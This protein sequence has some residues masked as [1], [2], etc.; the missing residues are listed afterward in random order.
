MHRYLSR[1]R[2]ISLAVTFPALIF[3]CVA[4]VSSYE[5]LAPPPP[6]IAPSRYAKKENP[7]EFNDASVAAGKK[8]YIAQCIACHGK[9]GHGDGARASELKPRPR[10][11]A[12]PEMWLETDGEIYYKIGKGRTP[13]PSFKKIISS[14]QNWQVINYMRTLS[15]K[16]SV[17]GYR[18][19]IGK[20]ARDTI[21]KVVGAATRVSDGFASGDSSSLSAALSDLSHAAD[22]LGSVTITSQD[23]YIVRAWKSA[24]SGLPF[25]AHAMQSASD[26]SS[27][28]AAL[29]KFTTVLNSAL[30]LFSGVETGLLYQFEVA[31]PDPSVAKLTWFQVDSAPKSPF[32]NGGSSKP[33]IVSVFGPHT[34]IDK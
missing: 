27:R 3:S 14:Q 6:W 24:V 34:S 18:F 25:A 15:P 13:M 33:S 8:V 1:V 17:L 10:N 9:T 20:N 11:L 2:N 21:G 12:I 29:T 7:V 32:Q 31:G 19:D 28:Y 22:G 26:E 5:L 30:R 23:K 16:P 4:V